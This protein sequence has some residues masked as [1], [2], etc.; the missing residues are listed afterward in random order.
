MAVSLTIKS[1]NKGDEDSPIVKIDQTTDEA[2]M[3][4]ISGVID[5]IGR[6]ETIFVGITRKNAPP[7]DYY[8]IKEEEQ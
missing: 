3:H 5:S 4:I 6:G 8:D 7:T 1:M 2:A